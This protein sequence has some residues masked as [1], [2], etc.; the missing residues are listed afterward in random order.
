[1][2]I[3]HVFVFKKDRVTLSIYVIKCACVRACVCVLA[4]YH[5][6][7]K[8]ILTFTVLCQEYRWTHHRDIF[9]KIP[10]SIC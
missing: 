5:E 8:L 10:S 1:M 7:E 9:L 4:N 3:S 2:R 6:I